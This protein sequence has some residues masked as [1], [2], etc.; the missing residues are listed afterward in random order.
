VPKKSRWPWLLLALF[1]AFLLFIPGLWV[2]KSLT[3]VPVH[4]NP[5]SIP[6]QSLAPPRQ[7]QTRAI[8]RAIAESRTFLRGSLKE[9]NIAGLSIAVIKHDEIVWAEAFGVADVD[10]RTPIAPNQ[11]FRI[12]TASI[13][14][15][16]TA[17]GL[18]LEEGKI[19]LND[20]ISTHVP[21]F[22]KKAHPITVRQLMAHLSGLRNDGGDESE[23]YGA[24]CK[25]PV[26]A[27]EYFAR[28]NLLHAPNTKFHFSNYGYILLA[29]AIES[30]S[31]TPFQTFLQQR[32]LNPLNMRD[33]TFE[34]TSTEPRAPSYFPGFAADPTYGLDP[35]RDLNFSCY[36]GA[37]GILSTA[38][39]L[40]RFLVAFRFDRILKPETT[41]TLHTMQRDASN[42]TT[43][44]GL[45]W[46]LRNVVLN[47]T[48][49]SAIAHDGM[50]LGGPAATLL[51]VPGKEVHVVVLSNTSYAPVYNMASTIAQAFAR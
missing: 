25:S 1:A 43:G 44:Y 41:R 32:V 5:A 23:L 10:K 15:T 37:S 30:A 50:I 42:K 48:N 18:L 14:L 7:S 51:S 22:P 6:S 45:G 27:L 19:K 38:S 21:Q 46:N 17:L 33:T 34:L 31:Q 49:F 28:K 26:D 47:G 3:A 40:V 4:Q 12:G 8:A 35:M 16:A 39:D 20:D 2:F 29:A 13:P 24:Q 11:R 9:H 36:Q